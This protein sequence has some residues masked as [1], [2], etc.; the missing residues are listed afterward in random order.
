MVLCSGCM[1]ERTMAHRAQPQARA[2]RPPYQTRESMT[3]PHRASAERNAGLCG[4]TRHPHPHPVRNL[5]GVGARGQVAEPTASRMNKP[6][7][8]FYTG[9]NTQKPLEPAQRQQ[10]RK[11]VNAKARARYWTNPE[12]ARQSCHRYA[13]THRKAV[14]H[15]R[16]SRAEQ[17]DY[18]GGLPE[19]YR[20]FTGGTPEQHA[21]PALTARSPY[22]NLALAPGKR[23]RPKQL[24]KTFRFDTVRAHEQALLHHD[25]H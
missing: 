1:P 23:G 22:A 24:P 2:T 4:G 10:N 16:C 19:I 5:F 6:R 14:I 18:T 13:R 3:T 12:K 7:N 20:R 11:E 25:R 15:H 8:R 21:Y 9:Q 17:R